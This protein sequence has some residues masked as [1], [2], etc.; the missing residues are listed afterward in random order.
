M[1]NKGKGLAHVLVD[2]GPEHHLIW[3]VVLDESGEVWAAPNPTV[4]G[5]VNWTMGRK[6]A[7]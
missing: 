1:E 7:S 3:V 6:G 2:Y 5:R 4:R